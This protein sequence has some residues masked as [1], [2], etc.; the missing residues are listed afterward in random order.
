M[1]DNSSVL[2]KAELPLPLFIRGKVRDTYDLGDQLLIIA[3][4]R[5]S[6]FD[7]VLPNGI[8]LKGQVL[9]QFSIFWFQK[10][11]DLMPNHMLEAVENVRSLDSYLPAESRF[12]YPEYLAKR[13]MVVKKAE[14]LPVECVVRGYISGSAWAEYKQEGTVYGVH[15]PDKLQSFPVS[16]FRRSVFYRQ[17]TFEDKI[18]IGHLYS[19]KNIF[20]L[21]SKYWPLPSLCD[22]FFCFPDGAVLPENFQNKRHHPQECY[23]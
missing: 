14:R 5:I 6:A 8:P 12:S 3:T 21:F 20:P 19:P 18:H 11:A 17:D 9:N 22:P 15:F 16:D 2:T 10:T 13:S 7:S 23:S 1:S 4:D